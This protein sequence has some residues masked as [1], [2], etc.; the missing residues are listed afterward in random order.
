MNLILNKQHLRFDYKRNTWRHVHVTMEGKRTL[1]L[2]WVKHCEK[3][4]AEASYAGPNFRLCSECSAP[5]YK[6]L[7]EVSGTA[8]AAVTRAINDGLLPPLKGQIFCV[9]CGRPAQCYDHRDYDKPL[10]VDPVCLK[11]NVNRGPAK[12]HENVVVRF[13]KRFKKSTEA[14]A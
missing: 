10:E 5:R 6:L 2:A 4:G 11:C 7:R 1:R 13:P 12:Q 3:C 8:H 9:D 14:V